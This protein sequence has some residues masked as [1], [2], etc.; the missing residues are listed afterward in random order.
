MHK[1]D[2][3]ARVAEQ[4][5]LNQA[6]ADAAVSAM[7][8]HITNALSRKE[9]VTLIGFGSFTQSQRTARTGRHPKT[10]NAIYIAASN[11]VLFKPGKA[12][13]DAVNQRD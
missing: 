6:K 8:E 11:G 5:E 10:G 12:L 13:K 4:T 7:L 3:V 9:A 2:L 1:T